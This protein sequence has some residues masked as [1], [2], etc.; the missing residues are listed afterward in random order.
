MSIATGPGVQKGQRRA[1]GKL[2]AD[3][4]ADEVAKDMEGPSEGPSGD[5]KVLD[6]ERDLVFES[7]SMARM[8]TEWTGSN[9][10]VMSEIMD[11]V[12]D[13]MMDRFMDA[14]VILEDIYAEVREPEVDGHGE[15]ATD[16]HGLVVWRKTGMGNHV[17]DWSRLTSKQRADFLMRLTV[18]LV[19]WEQRAS[20]LW[21]Q[22]MF[23]KA[24]W[25]ES[26]SHHFNQQVKGTV[27][28]RTAQGNERSADERYFAT[29]V[30]ALS[31]KADALVKS[32][33]RV[34][35]RLRDTLDY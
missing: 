33:E 22:A 13:A 18:G 2:V 17:E 3:E 25:T 21:T 8:R 5:D 7:T 28:H 9:A 32:M 14:Y 1:S 4:V 35:L 34:T 6:I 10:R 26:F 31:R 30:T 15:I 16:R 19:E 24:L 12:Q 11:A 27:D 20:D 29:Y 23:A